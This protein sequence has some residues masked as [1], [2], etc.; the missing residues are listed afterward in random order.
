MMTLTSIRRLLRIFT[1][2]PDW[3]HFTAAATDTVP[4]IFN[5]PLKLDQ[6]VRTQIVHHLNDTSPIDARSLSPRTSTY[7]RLNRRLGPEA[8]FQGDKQCGLSEKVICCR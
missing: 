2:L 4:P 8:K 1:T 6:L 7:K 5:L 3:A